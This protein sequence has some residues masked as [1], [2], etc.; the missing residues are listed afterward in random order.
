[1][2][3]LWPIIILWVLAALFS[4]KKK[5]PQAP[6]AS[7]TGGAPGARQDLSTDLASA[8]EQLKQ[9][10]LKV[11]RQQESRP[12]QEARERAAPDRDAR[13]R[14]AKERA[15]AYLEQ[16]RRK[17]AGRPAS[18]KRGQVF[19]P[20]GQAGGHADRVVRRP[21]RALEDDD[22]DKSSELEPA[23]VTLEGRDYDEE[24]ERIVAERRKAA[25]RHSVSREALSEGQMARRAERPA[26]AIGGQDEH[27][28]WHQRAEIGKAPAA[29][30]K[31][32]SP[33]AR[34]ADGSLRSAMI[35][36]E[37]LGKPLAERR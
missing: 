19:L 13:E 36:S 33:L 27:A 16:Q 17:A 7:A 4:G 31:A 24:A 32:V 10:E 3:G 35:L 5:K 21:V 20:G 15:Q 14:A 18:G 28:A 9:A 23:V 25:E 1:M 30:P 34:Y 26:V 6:G 12:Q 22:A 8:L 2:E 29:A 11:V 37:V